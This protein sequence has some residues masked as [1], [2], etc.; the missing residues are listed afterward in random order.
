M[1]AYARFDEILTVGKFR[2]GLIILDLK[3]ASLVPLWRHL[4]GRDEW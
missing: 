2:N 4:Y 1:K 3:F